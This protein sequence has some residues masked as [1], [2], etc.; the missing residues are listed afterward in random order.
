MPN[1][2]KIQSDQST[3]NALYNSSKSITALIFRLFLLPEPTTRGTEREFFFL[4]NI[5]CKVKNLYTDLT[6]LCNQLK[7]F[8]NTMVQDLLLYHV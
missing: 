3:R 7:M 6:L 2:K 8:R 1:K 5:Y 4:L